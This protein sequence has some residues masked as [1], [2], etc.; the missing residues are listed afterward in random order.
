MLKTEIYG[1]FFTFS[2]IKCYIAEKG[3]VWLRRKS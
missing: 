2:P 3:G 1:Y